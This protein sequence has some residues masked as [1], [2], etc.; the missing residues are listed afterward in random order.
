MTLTE[1]LPAV[2]SLTEDEK[3]QLFDELREEL[4]PEQELGED[5]T[6]TIAD[7]IHRSLE[8]QFQDYLLRPES[9]STLEEVRRKMRQ[10][11]KK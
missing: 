10:G 1:L 2:G 5:N 8:A 4:M 6:T 7:Q 3:W 11:R 9:A